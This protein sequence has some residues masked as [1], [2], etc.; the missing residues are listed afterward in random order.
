MD[1]PQRKPELN[2][3]LNLTTAVLMVVGIMIGSGVFKKIIPM[4]QLGLSEGWIVMA[5]IIAGV[6]T[7]FGAFTLTGLSSLTEESGGVYEYLRLSFGNFFSFLFGWTDFTII[8]CAS[9][10]ALG[11]LFAQTVN[12]LIPIPNP[13]QSL[14]HTSIADFIFPF[15]D[16]GVKILAIVSIVLL[17][18]VNYRGVQNG[19]II[20]NIFSSAKIMGILL[21]IVFGLFYKGGDVAVNVTENEVVHTELHGSVFLSALFAAMLSALWAYDG[22]LD[23]SFISGEIK[24][25]KRN[26]PLAVLG[27]ISI[28]MLLYVLVNIAYMQVVPV[29][30]LAAIGKNQIGASVVAETMIGK[31]GTILI[32]ALIMISVF[33]SLNA[34]ILSHARVYFRM[35]QENYFFKN[36]AKVHPVYR[37][38]YISLIYTA[39]WSCVLV[40]S[41]TFDMLTDM[42]V[43]AS[44]IFYI[45]IAVALFKMKSVGFIKEKVIGYPVLPVIVILF[46]LALLINTILV[47]PKETFT[48]LL[49]VLSGVIFYFYFRQKSKMP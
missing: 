20:S 24:K 28:A 37:T 30:K 5:W 44:F 16:F 17:T 47:Q 36:A 21:L 14:E 15:A 1:N 39:A 31:T 8:G 46:S 4:S 43:F 13:L 49:L 48:G 23:I 27:G 6:V 33:G 10:A 45:L 41:G 34:V 2:R 35:A 7:I 12:T 42:V 26:V 11:F 18:W 38:P 3:I 32:T 19:S 40:I 9:V 25:P 29:E 22:W